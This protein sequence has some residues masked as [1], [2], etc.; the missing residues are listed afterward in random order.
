M[1]QTNNRNFDYM[2]GKEWKVMCAQNQQRRQ[3]YALSMLLALLLTNPLIWWVL[4]TIIF[5]LTGKSDARKIEQWR[6][7]EVLTAEMINNYNGKQ[8]N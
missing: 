4:F 5:V 2:D 7:D 6:E 1:N 8:K 3:V